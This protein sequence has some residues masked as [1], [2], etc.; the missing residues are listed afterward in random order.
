MLLG[1]ISWYEYAKDLLIL[2]QLTV[3]REYH[4]QGIGKELLWALVETV[5]DNILVR[6]PARAERVFMKEMPPFLHR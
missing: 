4:G 1:S 2:D 5:T 3:I 6:V